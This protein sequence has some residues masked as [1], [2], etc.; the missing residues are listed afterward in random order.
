MKREEL[1][2]S[3]RNARKGI[4]RI[5]LI[6]VILFFVW[7]AGLIVFIVFSPFESKE[8]RSAAGL[9]VWVSCLIIWLAYGGIKSKEI[10]KS[11][12]LVCEECKRIFRDEEFLDLILENKCKKCQAR[13]YET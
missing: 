11:N 2:Y 10:C 6:Q 13:V 4:A 9:I 3:I 8:I 7:M 12:G 5:S 1:E